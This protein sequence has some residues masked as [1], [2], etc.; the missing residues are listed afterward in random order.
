MH[1]L[2]VNLLLPLLI[3]GAAGCSLVLAQ[4][5]GT[6][7]AI[8]KMKTP[9][10]GHSATLLPNGK[11]LMVSGNSVWGNRHAT[12][13]LYDPSTGIFSATGNAPFEDDVETATLLADGKVLLANVYRGQLYDPIADTFALTANVPTTGLVGFSYR[14]IL[15]TNG[16]VLRAGGEDFDTEM[17]FASADL[18]DSASRTFSPTGN[19]TVARK[20][21]TATLLPDG[22]ILITG[23]VGS[24]QF[25]AFVASAELYKPP[26]LVPAPVLLQDGKSQAAILHADTHQAVST[27]NP[28]IAGE[29]LEIYCTSLADGGVIPPQISIGGRLAQ[30]LYFGSSSY[31]GYNQVNFL[32]PNGVVPGLA[33][34]V[35]LTYLGRPSN[36]VTIGVQ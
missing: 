1:P 14:A 28:A 26:L 12:A 21:H 8:G 27:T 36:A 33:V 16:N 6:F 20:G 25:Y 22:T 15:L 34:P 18:Y 19:M 23:G 3:S 9:R 4:S 11:V 10:V 24:P 17:P 2:K 13:E 31:P 35:R 32:V 5:T 29:A 7:T 30:V